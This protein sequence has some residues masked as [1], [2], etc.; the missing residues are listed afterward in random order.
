MASFTLSNN[1]IIT[2]T[3]F[4]AIAGVRA[5]SIGD[6]EHGTYDPNGMG[7]MPGE[8]EVLDPNRMMLARAF[9]EMNAG[10][11]LQGALKREAGRFAEQAGTTYVPGALIEGRDRPVNFAYA[12]VGGQQGVTSSDRSRH[13]M[14]FN[15][16]SDGVL[17]KGVVKV[18]SFDEIQAL[19]F[20]KAVHIYEEL[21]DDV[22]R[23]DD[24]LGDL[25][26]G[27]HS[28]PR[29]LSE[30]SAGSVNASKMAY[31]LTQYFRTHQNAAGRFDRDMMMRTISMRIKF[32]SGAME[33]EHAF[34]NQEKW[35]E[36]SNALLAVQREYYLSAD[37]AWI[38]GDKQYMARSVELKR[39]A[40]KMLERKIS[41]LED[42]IAN[43]SGSTSTE[44]IKKDL[45]NAKMGLGSFQR[46]FYNFD[47]ALSS[48]KDAY[49][50]V[51]AMPGLEIEAAV[52]LL[53][54]D[55]VSSTMQAVRHDMQA[56]PV[57]SADLA[58][59]YYNGRS[60][61]EMIASAK[62][63]LE[64]EA[65]EKA[66]EIGLDGRVDYDWLR[67]EDFFIGKL[68]KLSALGTAGA[69][70]A[71]KFMIAKI[72]NSRR[73]LRSDYHLYNDASDRALLANILFA[74]LYEEHEF[75]AEELY[76]SARTD[77]QKVVAE[78]E[79]IEVVIEDLEPL[80]AD[81]AKRKIAEIDDV[82]ATINARRAK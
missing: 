43:A 50:L 58:S 22:E 76:L 4:T 13:A 72:A 19:T 44:E 42:K 36:L 37:L 17:Q 65:P 81:R 40:I 82:L 48:Y 2:G 27:S 24:V 53:K 46:K 51:T 11:A 66:I 60:F 71:V 56:D 35:L 67:E 57:L 10:L 14:Q 1:P 32:L 29:R 16:G 54:F 31:A 5:S 49:M 77:L 55:N 59:L 69:K 33:I 45:Y 25:R 6:I 9:A 74:R 64:K 73:R 7:Q 20:V 21:F 12:T 68:N 8:G 38:G 23:L 34:G 28:D 30:A 3:G 15:G 41:I 78:W 62:E 80:Y 39:N 75:D 70:I 63:L 61:S 79:P 47:A 52:A 26:R 18:P